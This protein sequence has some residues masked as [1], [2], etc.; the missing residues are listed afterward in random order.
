MTSENRNQNADF[1]LLRKQIDEIDSQIV[2]LINQ[3]AEIASQIGKS[4]LGKGLKIY[5]PAREFAIHQKI[6]QDYSGILPVHIVHDIYRELMIGSFE[7]AGGLK[8]ATYKKSQNPARRK[9][10]RCSELLKSGSFGEFLENISEKKCDFAVISLAELAKSLTDQ[11][12]KLFES[13][14]I[15]VV[16]L[17]ADYDSETDK[18]ID[19]AVLSAGSSCE[20]RADFALLATGNL[21]NDAYQYKL[22]VVDLN[23]EKFRNR[24]GIL[25][26]YAS[27]RGNCKKNLILGIFPASIDMI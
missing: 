14:E 3:R 10:G 9:F 17:I 22:R 20:I 23:G 5:S 1:E 4:K 25:E 11:S 12:A 15:S 8:I 19:F 16:S 6:Q 21:Q 26:K 27:N 24:S 7:I 13:E 2:K 18:L